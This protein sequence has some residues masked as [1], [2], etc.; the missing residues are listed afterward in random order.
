VETGCTF[1]R[2]QSNETERKRGRAKKRWNGKEGKK[3]KLA[4]EGK[5]CYVCGGKCDISLGEV[6]N[7]D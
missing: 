2:Q 1:Q 3:R 5:I 4:Q 7:A 6:T